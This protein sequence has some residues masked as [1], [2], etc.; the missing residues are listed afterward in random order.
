[1]V[2]DTDPKHTSLSGLELFQQLKDGQITPSPWAVLA[3]LHV[4]SP[5]SPADAVHMLAGD[6][7]RAEAGSV[8][9]P[10]KTEEGC[11]FFVTGSEH[12]EILEDGAS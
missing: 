6:F 2:G 12:D 4:G 5:D 9:D 10:I 8:H 1:M 7:Q 3:D 11:T